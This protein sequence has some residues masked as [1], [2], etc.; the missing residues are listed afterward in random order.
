MKFV[1][2]GIF[3]LVFVIFFSGCLTPNYY[4]SIESI[5]D[6]EYGAAHLSY[7]VTYSKPIFWAKDPSAGIFLDDPINTISENVYKDSLNVIRFRITQRADL[8]VGKRK[9]SFLNGL[10]STIGWMQWAEEDIDCRNL[11]KQKMTILDVSN[12]LQAIDDCVDECV[13]EKGKISYELIDKSTDSEFYQVA[14]LSNGVVWVSNAFEVNCNKKITLSFKY[15]FD[16]T[17]LSYEKFSLIEKK[18]K[19]SV[20]CDG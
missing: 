7:D 2:F 12:Y 20:N 8:N 15:I 19:E 16:S 4:E 5:E 13:L 3:G 6:I 9:E 1:Y 10:E 14:V 17:R 11:C 18:I